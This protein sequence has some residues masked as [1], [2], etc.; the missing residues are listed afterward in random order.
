MKGR[1]NRGPLILVVAAVAAIG[2]VAAILIG[3]GGGDST[4]VA[5]AAGCEQA[6]APEPEQVSLPAPEQTV[7]AGEKL[8]AV[9]RTSCGTFEIALD[10]RRAPK[11]TNSFAY[12]AGQGFYDGLDFN[13]VVS[14]F[15]VQGGD[16]LGDGAGGPGYSVVEKPPASLAYTEGIVAMAKSFDEPSGRSGSQFFVVTSLDAGYPP[17]YALLGKVSKGY[18]VVQRINKLGAPDEKPKQTVLIEKVT[19]EKG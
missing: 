2:V 10:T 5:S 17:E 15:V 8:T 1:N 13:R 14:G 16:P 3:R 7:K 4:T 12:L 19:I 18:D 9:V 11:T 6:E